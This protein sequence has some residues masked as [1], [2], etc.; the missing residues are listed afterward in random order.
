MVKQC[1]HPQWRLNQVQTMT[2]LKIVVACLLEGLFQRKPFMIL[3][4]FWFCCILFAHSSNISIF[5]FIEVATC[6]Q[7]ALIILLSVV[8]NQFIFI[9]SL[10]C[11]DMFL[12]GSML[13]QG[14]LSN[15]TNGDLEVSSS[16]T[17][18]LD[19]HILKT[20]IVL[21]KKISIVHLPWQNI[22]F[23]TYCA[24]PTPL[25]FV[26]CNLLSDLA[27]FRIQLHGLGECKIKI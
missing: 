5:G 16:F 11:F 26:R 13:L 23:R 19:N 6:I 12:Y 24:S 1:W 21:Q 7:H 2:L 17:H 4:M 8:A 14:L 15:G 20:L 3:Y 10:I 9:L 25:Q 27:L 18:A 22:V